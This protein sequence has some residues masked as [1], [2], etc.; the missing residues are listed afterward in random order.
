[1]LEPRR[2]RSLVK[3]KTTSTPARP[4]QRHEALRD[5]AHS[6]FKTTSKQ[7]R[8]SKNRRR[9]LHDGTSHVASPRARIMLR[10]AENALEP[11]DRA[12]KTTTSRRPRHARSKTKKRRR[13]PPHLRRH[14]PPREHLRSP[15]LIDATH[16]PYAAA[17]YTTCTWSRPNSRS[18][19]ASA[20]SKSSRALAASPRL[21]NAFPTPARA[22]ARCAP[23]FASSRWPQQR[24]HCCR[25][26]VA[27]LS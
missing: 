6:T 13:Q 5:V 11:H 9:S 27:L 10:S 26:P 3:F 18:S 22:C 21:K 19:I 23:R 8:A 20:R 25:R 12:P 16:A 14:G 15:H 4:L 24:A 17:P 1:M 2:A 7:H